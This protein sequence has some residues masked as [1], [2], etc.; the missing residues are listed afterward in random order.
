MSARRRAALVLTLALVVALALSACGLDQTSP[1]PTPEPVDTGP[2]LAASPTVDPL[3]PEGDGNLGESVGASN[4]TLAGLPAEGQQLE[5]PPTF[6]PQP[7]A[8]FLP[9][10]IS[11][12]DGLVLQATFYNSPDPFAPLVIMLHQVGGSRAD[13]EP[14]AQRLQAAGYAVL[15][16]D[17]RG[18]GQTG[19]AVNW[20]LAQSDVAAVIGLVQ[21]MDDVDTSHLVLVGAS[22]GAN[23][24]LNAC[25][26]MSGCAAAVLL[27]PGLDYR[28]ITTS[29]AMV[30]LGV[31]P[32]LIVA[33][34]GD[35]N[36]PADSLTLDGMAQGDHQLVV[37]TGAGHG[38]AMFNADP[39]LLEQIVQWIGARVALP[40]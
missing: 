8:A 38:T 28:G 6:T 22:I 16:L 26:D 21:A 37:L 23:L 11:A 2:I 25:A 5:D 9:L 17:L 7:T 31:R 33:S 14:L 1:T 40:Q 36:N 30:R 19:G 39:A 10:M 27:S 34:E 18:Y 35:D 32:T 29:D 12:S 15:T 3:M 24:A 20:S 13:W 4:P